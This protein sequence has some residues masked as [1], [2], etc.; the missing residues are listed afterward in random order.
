MNGNKAQWAIGIL[1][2]IVL[3]MSGYITSEK[4]MGSRVGSVESDVRVIE[5]G[6]ENNREQL[7]DIKRALIRIED[8]IDRHAENSN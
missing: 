2:G 3:A 7:L 1:I 4:A 8:K 5:A 6:V